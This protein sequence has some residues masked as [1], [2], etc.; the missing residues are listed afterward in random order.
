[1][2][3]M[4]L[5]LIAGAL[6]SSPTIGAAQ[7]PEERVEEAVL[8]FYQ[9]L[10]DNNAAAWSELVLEGGSQFGR[11]GQVLS[12]NQPNPAGMQTGFDSGDLS[13]QLTVHN[14]D[15]EVYDDTAVATFYTTGPSVVGGQAVLG[16][17]RV[18][19]VWIRKAGIG[20]PSTGTSLPWKSE[21]RTP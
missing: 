4:A 19:Q 15:V 20:E 18:T 1:M 5:V 6:V 13:F 12:T 10:A 14:L 9:H 7:S 21:A 16:T 11:T 2:Y 3:R 8:S 17:H